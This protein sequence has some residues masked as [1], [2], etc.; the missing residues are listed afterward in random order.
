MP[1][2]APQPVFRFAPSPNG[3]LHLGHALSALLNEKLAREAGGRLLLRIEDVD[4]QRS[5]PEFESDIRADL[6]WLGIRFDGPV[7]RQS[8][9]DTLYRVA[10]D[11]LEAQG[12]VY[13]AFLSRKAVAERQAAHAGWPRDP[14]GAP[15]FPPEDRERSVEERA[16]RLASGEQPAFRLDI[17]KAVALTGLDRVTWQEAGQT[18]G[19]DPAQFGD[20]VL[21]TRDGSWTYHLAVTVDDADQAVTDIVR[22]RDLFASTA[23]HRLLQGALGLPEPR[24][25]HHD[26]MTD[27]AGLKLSKSKGA[28]P[29]RMLR[30]SGMTSGDVRRALGFVE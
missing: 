24:Y 4:R 13:P 18:V 17:G 23:V 7:V 20:V 22:G 9:R 10:F 19:A 5:R 12:L 28:P 15:L 6:D 8:E 25:R 26:L 27:D 30:G 29:L 11:L 2:A 3:Q 21:K 16:E 1:T 14:D